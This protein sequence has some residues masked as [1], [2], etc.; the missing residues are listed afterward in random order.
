MPSN[1]MCGNK[2]P[3]KSRVPNAR[4]HPGL[5]VGGDSVPLVRSEIALGGHRCAKSLTEVVGLRGCPMKNLKRTIIMVGVCTLAV[6]TG[7]AQNLAAFKVPDSPRAFLF[8]IRSPSEEVTAT[9]SSRAARGLEGLRTVLAKRFKITQQ[10]GV[11]TI[12]FYDAVICRAH[13]ITGEESGS[14]VMVVGEMSI[15]CPVGTSVLVF[16]RSMR[17]AD[18]SEKTFD[19]ATPTPT[20]TDTDEDATKKLKEM[21]LEPPEDMDWEKATK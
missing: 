5:R 15:V 8:N 1:V 7:R 4:Q 9:D 11:A 17:L 13:R 16:G 12:T 3:T 6:A 19:P 18:L 20:Q 2:W 10:S 14:S 21:G